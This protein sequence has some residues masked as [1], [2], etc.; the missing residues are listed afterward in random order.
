MS[1]FSSSPAASLQATQ[2]RESTCYRSQKC[3]VEA[4]GYFCHISKLFKCTI[5]SFFLLLFVFGP[6]RF[7]DG[8]MF[9][10]LER[11][12]QTYKQRWMAPRLSR[13]PRPTLNTFILLHPVPAAAHICFAPAHYRSL[14]KWYGVFST[15]QDVTLHHKQNVP[16]TYHLEVR[17]VLKPAYV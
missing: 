3:I 13:I 15:I 6:W 10:F 4:H 2:L 11:R 12:G 8:N 16:K 5:L 14:V 1:P 17:E 9:P 7:M